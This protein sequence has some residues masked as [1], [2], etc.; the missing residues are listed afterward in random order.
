M[1]PKSGIFVLLLLSLQR[2]AQAICIP[3]PVRVKHVQGG[4]ED[5]MGSDQIKELIGLKIPAR[6]GRIPGLKLT[7]RYGKM[8]PFE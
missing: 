5:R 3:D 7:F 1:K 8:R 6:K 2:P 4:K